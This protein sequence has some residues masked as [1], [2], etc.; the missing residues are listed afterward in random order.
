V[1]ETQL[2]RKTDRWPRLSLEEWSS[3]QTTLHRWA[4][5]VGKTRLALSPMQN[6]WWQVVLYVTARGLTTSPIPRPNG[7]GTFEVDFDFIDHALVVR[8]SDGETRTIPLVAR[9]VADFFAE[10]LSTLRSL[11]IEVRLWPVPA[12]MPDTTRFTEDRVHA[13]Y[14]AGAAQRCWRILVHADRALKEFRGR[15]I[16]KSSPSHFWWGGFDIACTR[17][18]GRPAPR[19][20]GGIPNIADWVTRE[21]YS[22]ECI[23]AGWWPGA[24]GSPVTEPAFYAYSYPEPA[25]CDVAPIQPA[26]AY[27][28]PDLHEWILPYESVRAAQDPERELLEFLQSTYQAAADLAKWDRTALERHEP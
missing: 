4:Q 16:G 19:H 21:A 8:T 13:S 12:E 24:V 14:D 7:V 15:F 20:P 3:T 2:D 23:S 25:G 6:H 18:S 9:T 26:S 22:H 10:Y 28:H 1:I 27:Y 5:I 11:G 17:F